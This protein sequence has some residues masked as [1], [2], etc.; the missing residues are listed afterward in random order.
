MAFGAACERIGHSV[1]TREANPFGPADDDCAAEPALPRQ[2]VERCG[3]RLGSSGAFR[4]RRRQCFQFRPAHVELQRR[5]VLTT[6]NLARPLAEIFSPPLLKYT[7]IATALSSVALIGT[8]G[9]VQ[10]LPLWAD[11]MAGAANPTAKAYTHLGLKPP[12]KQ[13]DP[14]LFES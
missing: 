8:W 6:D 7:L 12:R 13:P 2:A 10:W 5:R 14:D 3:E 11:K 9:S 1:A 4:Q